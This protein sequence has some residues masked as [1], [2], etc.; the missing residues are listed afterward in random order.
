MVDVLTMKALAD[1]LP[2][3]E[4]SD[5]VPPELDTLCRSLL[6][7]DPTRRPAGS[8]ILR[9]LGVTR[10]S[11]PP[12][13]NVASPDPAAAFVGRQA[14]LDDLR[15]AFDVVRS[16]TPMT[17]RVGGAAGMGKSTLV[18]CFLDDLASTG[19]AVVLRG[20]VYERE[21]VP[22]KAVDSVVDALSR[23]LMHLAEADDALALPADAWAL[24][25]VF[26]VLQRV[27]GIGSPPDGSSDDPQGLRRR[28]FGALR[29]LLTTLGLRQPLVVFIDDAQWGDVDSAGL[30]LELLRPPEAPALLL[31]M[32]YRD[33]EANSSPLLADLR[34]NWPEGAAVR[35][36]D[37]GALD[38]EDAMKLALALLDARDPLMQRTARAVARESRGSPFLIEELVRSNRGVMA[39]TGATLAVLTLD[40][41]VSQR[42]ERLPGPARRL[43]EIVAVGGRPLPVSVLA[44][45]SSV[46][47][48]I[49]ELVTFLG[50]K[51]FARTGLR[52]G[53]DV[54]EIS[55]ARIGETIVALLTPATLREH[56]GRLA[57]VLEDAG[58]SDAE[59]IAMHWLG[60]GENDRAARFA[61]RAAEH[62]VTKLAFD[63][64]ARLF[65][66]TLESL[67]ASSPEVPR[68]RVR[69]AEA[70]QF[71]GRPAEAA[72]AYLAAVD[73]AAAAQ[74]VEFRRAAAEQL[75]SAGRIDEGAEMLHDVLAAAGMRG[76]R[77]PLSAV[78]WLVVYRFWLRCLG[79]RFK[80]RT[81]AEVAPDRRLRVDALFTAAAGFA[82]VDVIVGAC[83]QA[84][85][86]IEALR[87]GD[88]FQVMRALA[89]EAAQSA[90]VGG[91]QGKREIALVETASSLADREGTVEAHTYFDGAWGIGLFQRGRWVEA[92]SFLERGLRQPLF[93]NAGLTS[94]RL[95][96]VYTRAFLGDMKE[97]ARR[98]QRMIMDAEDRGDRYTTVN[99]RTSLGIQT[100]LAFDDP[101]AARRESALG[102]SQWTQ[103]GFHVQ[104][105]QAMIYD[106]DTELYVGNAGRAYERF[107]RDMPALKRSFLLHAG[108][109]R[110]MTFCARARCAISS[111]EAQPEFRRRRIA[112][113]R[114]MARRLALQGNAWTV[115]LSFMVIAMAENA[116]GNRPGAIAALREAAHRFDATGTAVY[117]SLVRYRLGQ[118]CGGEEGKA[119]VASALVT[120][121]AQGIRNPPRWAGV[122]VPGSWGVPGG[123][124]G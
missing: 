96:A 46:P 89:M 15:K 14:Q 27:P 24:A 118:A 22:Y 78:F 76:P 18:N 84:R 13:A 105:W 34:E 72:H 86:V 71:A 112:E 91:P 90:S 53:R 48:S 8:E 81:L 117:G 99:L 61:E 95:F 69:L 77:S 93:G 109:V 101:E 39:A 12:L 85:H 119:F 111:I 68:L 64:A 41:M 70:L 102:L 104:H 80:E 36:I 123:D 98:A 114:S 1:P 11:A 49:N 103:T 122:H 54:V 124:T 29:S 52:E 31:L 74:R 75:I 60:A 19:E 110:A 57:R 107:M 50:A 92:Q 55:N 10:S 94:V 108:F 56:H 113:A 47:D 3:S 28:A 23:H 58:G 16:G 44:E 120:M 106:A 88:R 38:D 9:R 97:T 25:R 2:P 45:A 73:G 20:R 67:P 62:A 83:M 6:D 42:L 116:A 79:L 66:L 33:S 82:V 17:V 121:A 26:P 32:T 4:C 65:R 63:R 43:I 40:Q 37:V 21:A 30:L 35:D 51:R 87:V 5:G 115:A 7:R 59:A 100:A